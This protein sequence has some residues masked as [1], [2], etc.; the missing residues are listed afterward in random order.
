MTTFA[1]NV[2]LRGLMRVCRGANAVT[3]A[4]LISIASHP[5][6]GADGNLPVITKDIANF[7]T[8]P[9]QSDTPRK[10]GLMSWAA[11]KAR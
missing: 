9:G 3:L 7:L 1:E 4:A 10:A 6:W 8:A 5:V 2:R 11:S